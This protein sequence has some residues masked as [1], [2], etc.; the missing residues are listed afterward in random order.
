MAVVAMV[1]ITAVRVV[2]VKV[3]AWDTVIINMTVVVEVLVID[4]FALP[5][6]YALDAP[7]DVSVDL[8]MDA[9]VFGVLSGI[10]V[11]VLTDVNT[12]VFAVVMVA[13][14]FPVLT[15]LEEFSR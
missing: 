1:A 10:G 11:E 9:L 7:S 13:L 4:V 6:S 8:F 14:K 5:V 2:V 3:L 15:A 12:N